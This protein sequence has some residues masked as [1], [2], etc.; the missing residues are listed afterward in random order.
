MPDV[1]TPTPIT[2]D[3][4]PEI[5]AKLNKLLNDQQRHDV[6]AMVQ[7]KNNFKPELKDPAARLIVAMS[8]VLHKQNKLNPLGDQVG[9]CRYTVDGIKECCNLTKLQC[10]Q[11]AGS[12]W[13]QT[14]L[15]PMPPP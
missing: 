11:I 6:D 5:I 8:W 13:D 14:G 12:S 2:S 3:Q 9:A 7:D 4:K 10:D 15:C 1:H